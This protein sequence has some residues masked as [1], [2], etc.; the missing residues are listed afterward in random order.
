MS[1]SGVISAHLRGKANQVVWSRTLSCILIAVETFM[2]ESAAFLLPTITSFLW[3]SCFD[4]PISSLNKRH[5]YSIKRTKTCTCW[6]PQIRQFLISAPSVSETGYLFSSDP[7][8]INSAG[9]QS[10]EMVIFKAFFGEFVLGKNIS[11]HICMSVSCHL[12]MEN[13]KEH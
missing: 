4:Q 12:R 7:I 3:W 8:W 2:L 9:W 13:K 6:Q 11:K 10:K 5:I 1:I